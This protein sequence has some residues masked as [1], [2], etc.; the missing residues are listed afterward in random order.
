MN[1]QGSE[2]ILGGVRM[3]PRKQRYE[4]ERKYATGL[5]LDAVRSRIYMVK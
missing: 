1:T 2:M 5:Q 3:I 4:F